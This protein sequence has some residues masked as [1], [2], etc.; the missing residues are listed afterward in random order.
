MVGHV[1]FLAT[2]YIW[3]ASPDVKMLNYK[4]FLEDYDKIEQGGIG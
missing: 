3:S 1:D 2:K 4:N